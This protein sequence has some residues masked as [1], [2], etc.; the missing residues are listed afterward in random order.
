M[1]QAQVAAFDELIALPSPPKLKA[2]FEEFVNAL[3]AKVF[4]ALEDVQRS[5]TRI[6]THYDERAYAP[7]AK[8][9]KALGLR[10]CS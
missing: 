7:S 8:L 1:H 4:R 3:H 10:H 9:A 6:P 2:R 5:P